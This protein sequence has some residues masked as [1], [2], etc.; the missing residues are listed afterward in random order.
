MT[1]DS[2]D[3]VGVRCESGDA[4]IAR[5]CDARLP[6]GRHRPGGSPERANTNEHLTN[7]HL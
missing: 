1:P 5:I 4:G 2:A 7:E 6:A 3:L